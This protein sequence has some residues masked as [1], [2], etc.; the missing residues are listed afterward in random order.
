MNRFLFIWVTL[1]AALFCACGP[2]QTTRNTEP[3]KS[4][5]ETAKDVSDASRKAEKD[6]N[7]GIRVESSEIPEP[8]TKPVAESQPVKPTSSYWVMFTGGKDGGLD[9]VTDD[10]NQSDIATAAKRL[11]K[12]PKTTRIIVVVQSGD[13]T[14][15]EKELNALGVSAEFIKK[16]ATPTP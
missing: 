5:E 9:S 3:L 8:E 13:T 10:G 11:A 14:N 7:T 15:F 6:K 12:F 16:T 2:A 4:G 1:C